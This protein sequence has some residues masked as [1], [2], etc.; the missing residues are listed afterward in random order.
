MA[1][2]NLKQQSR[3][4]RVS[5]ESAHESFPHELRLM[6]AASHK[7]PATTKKKG[8]RALLKQEN[9]D[10]I[11]MAARQL[12]AEQGYEAAT[13][14]QIAAKAGLGLGTL[15]NYISDKRDLIYLIF[16]EE[17]DSLTDRA[18]A[19]PRSWQPFSAKS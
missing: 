12:F 9:K 1:A 2:L 14:R 18:L 17:V 11:V 16:N 10:K 8:V 13:L 5:D 19:A 3:P 15:F 7:K 4:S 6:E